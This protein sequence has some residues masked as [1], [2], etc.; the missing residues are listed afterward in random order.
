MTS[1]QLLSL[2]AFIAMAFLAFSRLRPGEPSVRLFT[3]QS[4]PFVFIFWIGLTAG[5][6]KALAPTDVDESQ[7]FVLIGIVEAVLGLLAV[8]YTIVCLTRRS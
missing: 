7:G 4:I 2:A 1:N 8:V 5:A 3:V 6:W